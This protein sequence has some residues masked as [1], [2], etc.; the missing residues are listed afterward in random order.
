VILLWHNKDNHSREQCPLFSSTS[1]SYPGMRARADHV[2]TYDS[3]RGKV[4]LFGGITALWPLTFNNDTWEWD[5]VNWQQSAPAT[6][7]SARRYHA[8]AFDSAH[9]KAV[10]FGG[11]TGSYNDDTWEWDGVNWTQRTLATQPSARRFHA[12][13]YDNARGKVVM[14]GGIPENNETWEWDGFNWQ[15]PAPA[16]KPSARSGHAMAYDSSRGKVVM[17]GGRY[18]STY[19]NETWEWDGLTWTQRTG[20]TCAGSN[21]YVC[22]TLN[23]P[24]A[25]SDH[26]MAYDTARGKV[27]LFGGDPRNDETWEWDGVNWIKRKPGFEAIWGHAMT[28]DSDRGKVVSFGGE[29]GGWSSDETWEWTGSVWRFIINAGIYPSGRFWHAVAYDSARRKVVMFGG[30]DENGDNNETWELGVFGTNGTWT[31]H[32]PATNPSKR[33]QHAMAYDSAHGKV[34]MF[35][36]RN[37]GDQTWEW[38]GAANDQ[39]GQIMNVAFENAGIASTDPIQSVSIL[40]NA[41]GTGYGGTNCGAVD[42]AK[43]MVWNTAYRAGAWFDVSTNSAPVS[44]PGTMEWSTTDKDVIVHLFFGD[45][46]VIN[47]AVVPVSTN[48]CGPE[49]GSVAVGY[50]EV[51][52]KYTLP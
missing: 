18:D 39:P 46:K 12:I 1:F 23:C 24:S 34:I 42:G 14:F 13:T 15:Q 30:S 5:G 49:M 3:V 22:T 10:M 37:G 45:T 40:F 17:F 6:K 36:G 52:V 43:M 8:M 11:D 33:S 50:A 38:N 32:A 26:A 25:R 7:P 4:V 44:S 21:C 9:G 29:C 35:S 20:T 2:L 48:G 28:Y 41:G 16:T 31:L 19:Y 47:V 51:T 27:V